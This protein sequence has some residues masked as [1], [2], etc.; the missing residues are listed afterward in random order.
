MATEAQIRDKYQRT[1]DAIKTNDS[2]DAA[3]RATLIP[4]LEAK[5]MGDIRALE[6]AGKR[7][8]EKLFIKHFI[9]GCPECN[10]EYRPSAE[11][12]TE[13]I[14]MRETSNVKL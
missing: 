5:M 4:A 11:E 7:A 6:Q 2:F 13:Y 1:I 10:H 3:Q 8:G 9:N 14:E 12:I